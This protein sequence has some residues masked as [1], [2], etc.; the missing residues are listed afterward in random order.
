MQSGSRWKGKV[1]VMARRPAGDYE[2]ELTI[3]LSIGLYIFACL[4]PALETRSVATSPPPGVA[5]GGVEANFGILFLLLG[6]AI[7]PYTFAWFANITLAM[8]WVA[9][10]KRRWT[11]AV[12]L[13]IFS[14]LLAI[15]LIRIADGTPPRGIYRS[16]IT[17]IERPF[18]GCY[19]W[20]GSMVT[21][22]IGSALALR[23]HHRAQLPRTER[24]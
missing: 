15:D 8:G 12:T 18:P 24:Q 20:L 21:L 17:F 11:G 10:I 19:L 2:R 9:L 7:V 1:A 16:S 13:S 22:A 6:W 4:T 5:Q 23:Q 14:L 3:T